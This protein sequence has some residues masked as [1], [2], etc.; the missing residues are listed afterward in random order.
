[1][2]ELTNNSVQIENTAISLS[3]S[4]EVV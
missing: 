3:P 1:L 4:Q 2:K